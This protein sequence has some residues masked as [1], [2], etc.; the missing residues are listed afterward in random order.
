MKEFKTVEYDESLGSFTLNESAAAMLR[1]LPLEEQ[2]KFFRAR[3]RYTDYML[4]DAND[5]VSVI[6]HEGIIVGVMMSDYSGTPRPCYIDETI[7]TW[8]SED[9]NGAGYKTR[10]E[11][12]KLIFVQ[13]NT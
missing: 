1:G 4:A 5:V 9:N 8:D 10:V 3:T 7:C 12:T 6:V 13:N 11:Y 2:A